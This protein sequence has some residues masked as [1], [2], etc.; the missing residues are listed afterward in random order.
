[1][2]VLQYGIIKKNMPSVHSKKSTMTFSEKMQIPILIIISSAQ[3]SHIW[4]QFHLS[5]KQFSI[6]ILNS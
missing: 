1:M 3:A 5:K 6:K 4:N 2:E